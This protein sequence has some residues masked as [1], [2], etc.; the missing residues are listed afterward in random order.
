MAGRD[1]QP[2][3]TTVVIVDDHL[4]FRSM[5]RRMLEEAGFDVVGE[6]ADGVS[7]LASVASL[8]PHVVLLDLQ[9]PDLDG[10]AVA[11][12]LAEAGTSAVVILISSRSAS[13]YGGRLARTPALGFIAKA[14]LSASAVTVMLESAG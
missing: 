11:R 13:D 8:A 2:M 14:E 12:R 4:G 6:A 1:Y 5:A 7:A 10:F 9:L 3:A